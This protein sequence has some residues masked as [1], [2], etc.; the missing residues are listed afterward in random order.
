MIFFVKF[1]ADFC[2]I[3]QNY[4]KIILI[5]ILRGISLSALGAVRPLFRAFWTEGAKRTKGRMEQSGSL[6]DPTLAVAPP[7]ANAF[8]PKPFSTNTN[9][10]T[11]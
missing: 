7:S 5:I 8:F 10:F 11:A 3:C 9:N 6:K 4:N 2:N 1:Q